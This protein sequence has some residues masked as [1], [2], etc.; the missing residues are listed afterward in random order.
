MS[1]SMMELLLETHI[2]ELGCEIPEREHKFYPGRSWRFDFSWPAF[3]VA[4]EVEGG[5]WENGR[6][7]RPQGFSDD[8]EKYNTATAA[9]WRVYRFTSDMVSTGYAKEFI[10]WALGLSAHPGTWSQWLTKAR[11]RRRKKRH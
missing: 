2:R 6:H 7:V 11:P 4:V 8:A 1:T 5:I 9:G 10:A 3:F